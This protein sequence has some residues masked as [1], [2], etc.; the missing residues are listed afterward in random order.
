[1]DLVTE[2][3]KMIR[4]LPK[5]ENY[6]LADQMRRAAVSIP[7]NIA[8]GCSRDTSREII[9]FMTIALGS[10]FELET[11]L[12]ICQKLRYVD[13]EKVLSLISLNSEISKML[14]SFI[15]RLKAQDRMNFSRQQS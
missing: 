14:R 11:Q 1:M 2:V 8:E 9:R 4:S 13:K 12:L 5:E 3:Y 6:G 15:N 10:S 7:S